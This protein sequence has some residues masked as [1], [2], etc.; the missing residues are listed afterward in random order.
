MYIYIYIYIYTPSI[1]LTNSPRK[2][3][4]R[5]QSH[6]L[7]G[8]MPIKTPHTR[9]N[10]LRRTGRINKPAKTLAYPTPIGLSCTKLQSTMTGAAVLAF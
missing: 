6:E 9:R 5:C 10:S 7:H 8:E 1:Y 3:V 4:Y 2:I